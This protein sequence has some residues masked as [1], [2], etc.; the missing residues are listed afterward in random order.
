MLERAWAREADEHAK[1]Q[2]ALDHLD[3][4]MLA[5]GLLDSDWV[6]QR[7]DRAGWVTAD[8]N[9]RLATAVQFRET[10]QDGGMA[11]TGYVNRMVSRAKR[12]REQIERRLP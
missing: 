4:L 8:M 5:F 11:G 2:R 6:E 12:N 9:W 1:R 7:Q 10:E 3:S